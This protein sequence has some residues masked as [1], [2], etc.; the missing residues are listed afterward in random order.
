MD[1][2]GVDFALLHTNPMLG[3]SR[4]YQTQCVRRFPDRLRSMAP[5]DEWRMRDD[6]AARILGLDTPG[7]A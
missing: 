3:R 5:V 6:T 4:A 2:A 1:Y 7:S